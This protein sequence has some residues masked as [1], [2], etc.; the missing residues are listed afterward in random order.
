MHLPCVRWVGG[1]AVAA[2]PFPPLSF[3]LRAHASWT[4][5]R[6]R[7]HSPQHGVVLCCCRRRHGILAN[8]PGLPLA[9]NA[10]VDEARWTATPASGPVPLRFGQCSSRH[11]EALCLRHPLGL[12]A[13]PAGWHVR[14]RGGLQL[15]LQQG[16]LHRHL[17][18]G[19][20]AVCARH[21]QPQLLRLPRHA[22]AAAAGGHGGAAARRHDAVQQPQGGAACCT[23]V[24]L[25]CTYT[26]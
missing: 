20:D 7:V 9:P 21:G 14:H 24:V 18:G 25:C 11:A 5:E 15:L 4:C 13:W 26:S 17:A 23:Y 1:R 2:P 22:Q 19:H 6:V 12:R 8:G 3:V 10:G 16:R